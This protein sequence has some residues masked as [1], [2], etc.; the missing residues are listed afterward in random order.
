MPSLWKPPFRIIYFPLESYPER[1]T[2]QLSCVGGWM[3]T[4]FKRMNISFVRIEGTPWRTVIDG[5]GVAGS[6]A[7]RGIWAMSQCNEFLKLLDS[8]EIRDTDVLYFDEFWQP[9]IE[10]IAYALSLKGMP[11]RMYAYCWAQ[12]VDEHDF[13]TSMLPWIRHFE[14]GIAS[15]LSG[16]FV[17]CNIHKAHML[18]GGLGTQNRV[19][20]TG[21]PFDRK[22]VYDSI[23][24]NHLRDRNTVIYTGRWDREKDPLTLLR[25]A[26]LHTHRFLDSH[27]LITTSSPRLR[28]NEPHLLEALTKA[29]GTWVTLK[30]GL[31]KADY[32]KE[33]SKAAIL[34]NCADQDYVSFGLLEGLT[35]GAT[36]LYP[37]YR[38][39]L[40]VFKNHPRFLYPKGD[41]LAAS[42]AI[43]R[44]QAEPITNAERDDLLNPFTISIDKMVNVMQADAGVISP[45]QYNELTDAE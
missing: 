19:H 34:F 18:K 37:A 41:T 36:P 15:L 27:F 42:D 22:M 21:H 13:T 10:A 6:P 26:A 7:G 8:G 17:A 5:K 38:S 2:A 39:F 16:I 12:S 25:L 29:Q 28:S 30:E 43:I 40:E 32:Y 3:E 4:A 9:G 45:V 24:H 31:T 44:L 14:T 23:E 1:Y 33:L 11:L 20:V 35:F